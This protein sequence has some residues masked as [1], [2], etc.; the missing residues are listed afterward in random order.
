MMCQRDDPYY[1]DWFASNQP[2]PEGGR[3]S[4][5][6]GL[7][8]IRERLLESR[9]ECIINLEHLFDPNFGNVSTAT[10]LKHCVFTSPPT[11]ERTSD[12]H[13]QSM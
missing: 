11:N 3:S 13:E 9:V 12:V 5:G 1:P 7:A 2:P 10:E 4:S 8:R 6:S